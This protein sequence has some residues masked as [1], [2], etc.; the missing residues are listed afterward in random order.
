[1]REKA[2]D[3]VAIGNAIV[4]I[5]AEADDEFLE[6]ENIVKGTMTL[7][8]ENK[9]DVLYSRMGPAME[10]SGGSV[11]NMVSGLASFGGRAAFIGKVRDD[12]LGTVFTHD[13]RAQGVHFETL[14]ASDGAA[15]ARCLVLVTQDAQRSMST[16]LGASVGLMPQDISEDL[17]SQAAV[18]CMEGYLWDIA[19]AQLAFREAQKIVYQAGGLVAFCLSDVFCVDRHRSDFL[20]LLKQGADIMF[21]NEVEVM[22][23]Y[24]VDNF[25]KALHAAREE[26]CTMVITRSEWG[27]VI[28][29]EGEVYPVE[30]HPTDHLVDTTG[31]G[32][33]YAAGFLYGFVRGDDM[34]S[35]GWLGSLAAA[36]A[37]SHY[38]ARPHTSLADLA[39][40]SAKAPT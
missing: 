37:I 36:E 33:L 8:D 7:I 27:S 4:D 25:D 39:E 26:H 13:I 38:G 11:A 35:C 23:L 3:V 24:E 5:I 15:T 16:Y 29:R 30:T 40:D 17:V 28:V 22:A 14:P 19:G 12:Q 21:G 18:L 32:D 10:M 31:A 6:R 34:P 1:M 20:N 2:F 9:A